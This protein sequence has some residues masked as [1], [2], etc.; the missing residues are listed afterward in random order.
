[1]GKTIK[2]ILDR[3]YFKA[4]IKQEGIDL[5]TSEY[6]EG[7]NEYNNAI[8]EDWASGLCYTCSEVSA[9]T[10]DT[11]L[12]SWCNGYMEAELAM[13][14]CAEFNKPVP[15]ALP[16]LHEKSLRAVERMVVTIPE[17]Y[18]SSILPVGGGEAGFIS[19]S[20]YFG[21]Q[22][23]DDLIDEGGSTLTN[24]EGEPLED[25]TGVNTLNGDLN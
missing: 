17:P 3:A 9:Q 23:D 15:V 25:E 24:E 19:Q 1:M 5:T 22:G 7:I 20:K 2:Q 13:R 16:G 18:Y 8:K 11:Y 21:R 4:G 10:D 6:D 12:P 14:F